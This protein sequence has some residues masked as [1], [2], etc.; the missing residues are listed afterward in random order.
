MNGLTLCAIDLLLMLELRECSLGG[1]WRPKAQHS[2]AA[3]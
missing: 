2:I 3:V 1:Q